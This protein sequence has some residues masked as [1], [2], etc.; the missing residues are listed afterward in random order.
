MTPTGLARRANFTGLAP[1]LTSRAW[2][3]RELYGLGAR[4]L[5]AWRDALQFNPKKPVRFR[6]VKGMRFKGVRF[7]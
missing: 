4:T 1:A 3:P 5:R 2:R 6:V 7:R